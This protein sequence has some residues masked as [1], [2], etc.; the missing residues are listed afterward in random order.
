MK[1][2]VKHFLNVRV[3]KPSVNAPTFGHVK[4]GTILEIDGKLY[5]GDP[6]EGIDTW[7][8]DEASNYYWSGGIRDL[9][10][11]ASAEA[12]TLPTVKF[13]YNKML[14][15]PDHFKATKGEGAVIAIV[16]TGCF[17]H[18]ALVDSI[19]S[20][21]DVFTNLNNSTDLSTEGHGTFIAGLIAAKESNSNEICG[22]APLAKL[23]VV[24]A[25][26]KK[27]VA[28]DKIL[29][30]LEWLRD[31]ANP[32]IINLSVNFIP[33]NNLKKSFDDIFELFKQ[34][35]TLLVAA[36]QNGTMIY[37]NGTFYP[38]SHTSVLGVGCV[39]R[40]HV[41]PIPVSNQIDHI[42][43]DF[44]F[45]STRNFPN[46]YK[47]LRGS[48]MSAAIV[49]GA[50]ALI[51]SWQKKNNNNEDTLG[52]LDGIVANLSPQNFDENLKIYKR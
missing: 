39:D 29:A 18:G 21:F 37:S 40:E 17:K 12:I 7:V 1:V 4:P 6:F 52:I 35:K 16:D 23:I 22:V 25:I 51:R 45:L 9:G 34:R 38:A 20:R 33:P 42:V 50:L 13:N 10:N 30:A 43:P 3:G 36:G 44:N 8:K 49:S 27:S 46:S 28:G 19:Q 48:S 26:E 5:K 24:R 15:I 41:M 11:I 2:T 31:N 47:N 14:P 32:D